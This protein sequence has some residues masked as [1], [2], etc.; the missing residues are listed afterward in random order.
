MDGARQVTILGREGKV[1]VVTIN[2]VLKNLKDLVDIVI[3]IN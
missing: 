3:I 2:A 1:E